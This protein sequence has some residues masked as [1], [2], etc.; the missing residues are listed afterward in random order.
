MNSER[1][2]KN[3]LIVEKVEYQPQYAVFFRLSL[4]GLGM[5]VRDVVACT[6]ACGG[7]DVRFNSF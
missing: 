3:V 2:Q 4:T 6:R 1:P 7:V 5:S